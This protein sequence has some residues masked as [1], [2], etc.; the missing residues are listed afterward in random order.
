MIIPDARRID[1][2]A[3]G[4]TTG[5]GIP[6]GIPE[7]NTIDTTLSPS[8]GDD[9]TA[10]NN[11]L[12]AAPADS[13]VKLAAGTFI[14]G[15]TIRL[16]NRNVLRGSGLST[17]ISVPSSSAGITF[18]FDDFQARNDD[19]PFASGTGAAKGATSVTL[20]ATP[21]G[22]DIGAGM[23]VEV[24]QEDDTSMVDNSGIDGIAG[25]HCQGQYVKVTDWDSTSRVLSF[26][27][28]LYLAYSSAQ[29]PR[30]R[31]TF[32]NAAPLTR[33][34]GEYNGL[35]DMKVVNEN[36]GTHDMVVMSYVAYSWIKN[37]YFQDGSR[38][39]VFPQA[40]FRCEIRGC[41]FSG[42]IGEIT[43]SRGYGIQLGTTNGDS[44]PNLKNTGMLIEDNIFDGCRGQIIL[45]YGAAGVVI[46]ANY[47][48]NTRDS[49]PNTS[50]KADIHVHSA[51]PHMNLIEGNSGCWLIV[52]DRF[53]GNAYCNTVFRNYARGKA[54][55]KI[56]TLRSVE[57]DADHHDYNIVGNILGYNG[58]V[59]DVASLTPAGSV[60]RAKFAPNDSWTSSD[61]VAKI[62][63][64]DGE[65]GGTTEADTD[66]AATVIDHG[67]YDFAT[68][69]ILWDG[70]IA[71]HDLPDSY[72]RT[73]APSWWGSLTW[74]P[75]DPEDTAT[76]TVNRIP[77]E[78]RYNMA[79]ATP[80][81]TKPGRGHGR[82]RG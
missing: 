75:Y 15:G 28:P 69:G 2:T 24:Q 50:Q 38:S 35:E 1:W 77:A 82:R 40:T 3:N 4:A 53:H 67:N 26:T 39:H 64:Y 46:H 37:V 12:A 14:V 74:P 6:G 76:A 27:P 63:G 7:R 80:R 48:V 81:F 30:I 8:G 13:V 79:L 31:Y 49:A 34:M 78:A 51:W 52:A 45:G 23:I 19:I 22:T 44:V 36:T 9:T 16:R 47:F 33:N 42:I 21:A 56:S 58:I 71:D 66:V 61:Y 68:P 10:I 41:T 54:S 55:G 70:G 25:T 32:L 60:F 65:G 20:A 62:Y 11:A 72:F 59:A 17:I 5:C 18:W 29:N 73:V 57:V 43:S